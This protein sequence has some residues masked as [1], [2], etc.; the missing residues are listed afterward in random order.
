MGAS[1]R[2]PKQNWMLAIS[3][4]L[5]PF[6]AMPKSFTNVFVWRDGRL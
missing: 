2:L 5:L 6:G 3:N 1:V 4:W